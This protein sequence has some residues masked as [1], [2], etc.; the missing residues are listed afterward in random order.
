MSDIPEPHPTSKILDPGFWK[1][2]ILKQTKSCI[3]LEFNLNVNVASKCE[4]KPQYYIVR[5]L[6][7]E[8]ACAEPK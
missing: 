3:K 4:S 5:P 7:H 8:R 2:W 6:A 1:K